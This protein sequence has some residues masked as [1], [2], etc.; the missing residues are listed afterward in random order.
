MKLAVKKTPAAG[1]A[2][3]GTQ[4]TPNANDQTTPLYLPLTAQTCTKPVFTLGVTTVYAQS[5]A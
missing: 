1:T 2:P 3:S 4:A 5:G